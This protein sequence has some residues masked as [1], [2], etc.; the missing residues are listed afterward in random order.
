MS[1]LFGAVEA[2][3]EQCTEQLV[4][5]VAA[6]PLMTCHLLATSYLALKKTGQRF[7]GAGLSELVKQ[8]HSTAVAAWA[9]LDHD[10][11]G[12]VYRLVTTIEDADA[13]RVKVVRDTSG[14]WVRLTAL[15]VLDGAAGDAGSEGDIPRR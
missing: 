5:E 2:E 14:M 15:G 3:C 1:S 7:D 11:F 9:T 10:L 4:A 6:D 8:Y 12:D 13:R